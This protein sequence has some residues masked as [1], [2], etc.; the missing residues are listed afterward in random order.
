MLRE[1][2]DITMDFEEEH[3]ITQPES[4]LAV[5]ETC[6]EESELE[7]TYTTEEVQMR[8]QAQK[9]GYN[10]QGSQPQFQKQQYSGQKNCQGNQSQNKS[11]YGSGYKPHNKVN[12]Q[13]YG[14]KSQYQGQHQPGSNKIPEQQPRISMIL[15][16]KFGLEQF[17]EM[18]KALQWVE[19]KYNKPPYNQHN[20]CEPS[21]GG[22]SSNKENQQPSSSMQLT[23]QMSQPGQI[24]RNTQINNISVEQIAMSLGSDPDHLVEA[25][26][27]VFTAPQSMEEQDTQEQESQ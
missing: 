23:H 15:P 14:N 16:M 24:T 20:R 8:S 3:Q 21:H 5:M 9:Q 19:D 10:Q 13:H 6:Y 4:D 1:A 18:T 22:N 11:G 7:E 25:L 26:E 12:N 2:M 27:D 17:L